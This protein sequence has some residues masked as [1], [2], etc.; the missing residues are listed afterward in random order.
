MG[1]L[2]SFLTIPSARSRRP[3]GPPLLLPA[4]FA[5]TLFAAAALLFLVEPM[6][7][8]RLLPLAGGTPGVWNTCLVFFQ[9]ALLLGY[10]YAHRLAVGVWPRWQPLAHLA[11]A[12]GGLA[13]A[14]AAFAGGYGPGAE[15][16]PAD[17]D[18]PAVALAAYLAAL[19]GPP[20][21]ALAATAP[22]VMR[23]FARTGHPAARD[24]Y[25]LAA[26]SNAGSLAGLLAYPFAVEPAL[27]LADQGTLWVWGFAAVVAL[28]A[29]CGVAAA[30]GRG[31]PADAGDAAV[32]P[33]PAAGRVVRWVALAALP[34]S[35]LLGVTTHVTTDVAPV[36]L[37][38]V[39]P[40]AL[41]LVSFVLAFARWPDRAHRAV[42]RVAPML[43][44][45][46]AVTLLTGA[47]RPLAVVA[48]LHLL[49]FFV[50][51]LLCHGELARDRPPPDRLTA[52]YLWLAAGGVV[53]G[54][55]NA[56]VAP[57]AFRHLGPVEYP[58][59][60]ALVAVVRPG[61][62]GR[63]TW[64]DLIAPLAL[65]GA[66]AALV[67]ILPRGG[68]TAGA[69]LV[70]LGPAVV[71]Y[72]FVG[73]PPRFALGLAA[74]FLAGALDPGPHGETLYRERNFFGT[75]RVTR[76]ADGRFVSL[77]H[78]TTLHGRQLAAERGRP[79]PLA[80]Y[81]PKG[82][83]GRTFATLGP[84]RLKRVAAVGLGVGALAAYG[85]PGQRW[86]FYEIDPAVARVAASGEHF[87]FLSTC[88]AAW[89]VV[90]GDARRQLARAADGEFDLIVLDAFSSDSVPVHLLTAEAF[91]LYL[92]KLAPNGVLLL[93][94]SNVHLD[95][96]PVVHRTAAAHDPPLAFRQAY[97]IVGED[98]AAAG[99]SDSQWALVARTAADLGR[100]ATDPY[101][102]R[103]P[104]Q[105]PGPVWTDDFGNLLAAWRR[106]EE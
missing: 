75:L 19:V 57:L 25:F 71:A 98:G 2:A 97:D 70:Y 47:A 35:L 48:G 100:A 18:L 9:T 72:T 21:V 44:L 67:L 3:E 33:P 87:T 62:M 64:A 83:A 50:A 53:G 103:P 32:S 69:G 74:L 42:G 58:L 80:Y 51:A 90:L 13:W 24:P 1:G 82:P 65:G 101:W 76:S 84:A 59:A 86:T 105:P 36:P 26:A 7:G 78:G 5:A 93:H 11:V 22:V 60:L 31:G 4:L 39:V 49:A 94:L 27:R 45:F 81:H 63:V 6:V 102:D 68:A 73:R 55:F 92:R 79:T 41:Y 95:L 14:W 34:S 77:V 85:E 106:S 104:P 29:L 54:L 20:F 15:W 38:W 37:L 61:G 40:L 30:R 56:L 89:D 12:A 52:F 88:R 43:L 23:W 99:R 28:L 17:G 16:V 10:L 8:K 91:E 66:T 96:P 46:T